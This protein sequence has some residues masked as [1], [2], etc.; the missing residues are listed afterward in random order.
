MKT[1]THTQARFLLRIFDGGGMCQV[2]YI[3]ESGVYADTTIG[4]VGAE[5]LVTL[6]HADLISE[7]HGSINQVPIHTYRITPEGLA[8]AKELKSIKSNQPEI[9]A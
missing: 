7:H 8:I 1:I 4:Q 2:V 9:P 5:D 6:V 3:P